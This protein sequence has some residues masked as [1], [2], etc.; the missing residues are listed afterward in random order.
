MTK[1][2]R[3]PRLISPSGDVDDCSSLWKISYTSTSITITF[4]WSTKDLAWNQCTLPIWA[5]AL[6]NAAC[7]F[8]EDYPLYR[9]KK[10]DSNIKIPRNKK[11]DLRS[12]QGPFSP[13]NCD[14]SLW[15][16]AMLLNGLFSES[17]EDVGRRESSAWIR[18]LCTEFSVLNLMSNCS[19]LV[20]LPFISYF[21]T[22]YEFSA[23]PY[24]T[25]E[26]ILIN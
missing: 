20:L 25:W 19:Y 11:Q 3:S 2:H 21:S 26:I 24:K 4:S 12:E 23:V 8:T 17:W 18:G 14:S 13:S 15:S 16:I 7:G 22:S 10:C 6:R 5:P 1:K 9:K